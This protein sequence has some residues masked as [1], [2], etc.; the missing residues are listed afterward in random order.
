MSTTL[1]A[2]QAEF[3]AG[4]YIDSLVQEKR[5]PKRSEVLETLGSIYNKMGRSD[6]SSKSIFIG[7]YLAQLR[8]ERSASGQ[9]T[10]FEFDPKEMIALD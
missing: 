7:S 5:L 3:E 6:D 1:T 2:N 8:F 4:K 9:V 10:D